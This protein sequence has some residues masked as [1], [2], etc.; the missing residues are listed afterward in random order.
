MTDPVR[1]RKAFRISVR[2]LDSSV[3]SYAQNHS[4]ARAEAIANLSDAWGLTWVEALRQIESVRRAPENDV[5]LPGRHPLAAMLDPSILHCVVHA[6]GGT[7]L[8]AG[9][10]DYFYTCNDDWQLKAAFYHGLFS[11]YR[12]DKGR[13]GHADQIMYELTALGRNVAAGEVETYPRSWS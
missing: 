6:Y 7:G 8:K 9:Y 12:R 5:K 3:I 13:H 1:L 2:G 10:R 4:R 11:V